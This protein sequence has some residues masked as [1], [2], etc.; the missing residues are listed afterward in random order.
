LSKPRFLRAAVSSLVL[1]VAFAIHLCAQSSGASTAEKVSSSLDSA[2]LPHAS[3]ALPDAPAPQPQD[4]D[5]VTV[6]N[7][8]IHVLKDQAA[9]WTSP[10][11]FKPHDLEWFLPL[12]GATGVGIATDHHVMSSVLSHDPTFNQNNLNA[13][14]VLVGGF[15][16]A[17][18]VL[19]GVGHFKDDPHAREAGIL[20][21][22]ALVD[23]L[24]VQEGMKLIFWRER[25]AA[26]NARGKFFQG[27]AGLDSA[28]PS[29]HSVLTWASAAVIAEE[30]PSRWTR[31]GVYTLATGVSLTRVLGQEHFP[32]DVLVGSAAGWLV[33]HYVFRAH[34]KYGPL[35][36]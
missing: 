6:V 4:R 23:G 30:Y 21:G 35:R 9:I 17:P 3:A 12:A 13:S 32:T 10:L 31:F 22:E 5:A 24:V 26:D 34:H 11:R 2:P 28:F 36:H 25:P 20:G 19:Y 16:A 33:G 1:F 27:S 14:N 29:S 7:T 15:I 8:P 18:V